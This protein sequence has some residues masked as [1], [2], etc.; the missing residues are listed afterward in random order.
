M[1]SD[2][3]SNKKLERS[4]S[5]SKDRMSISEEDQQMESECNNGPKIKINYKRKSYTI[6][7]KIKIINESRTSSLHS[8]E[9]KYDISRKNIRRWKTQIKELE[10]GKK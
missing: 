10:K 6:Q 8:L 5:I 7:Q 1:E 4:R 9:K 2:D 3:S